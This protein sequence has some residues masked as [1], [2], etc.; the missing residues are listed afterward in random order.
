MKK[1]KL[2]WEVKDDE[3]EKVVG[4]LKEGVF[5]LGDGGFFE[6]SC[7]ERGI[8]EFCSVDFDVEVV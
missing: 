2:V 8:D 6:E 7:E 4:M 1:V 5:D 3:V